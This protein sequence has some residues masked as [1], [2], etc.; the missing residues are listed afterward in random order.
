MAAKLSRGDRHPHF[1]GIPASQPHDPDIK[2]LLRVA[3]LKNI[4]VATNRATADFLIASLM[5]GSES[6]FR[7]FC[8]KCL[9]VK[10][11]LTDIIMCFSKGFLMISQELKDYLT[12]RT[13]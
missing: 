2:A 11:S 7:P 6:S 10:N 4:P 8:R 1:S 5:D 13:V 12:A 3:A 9:S